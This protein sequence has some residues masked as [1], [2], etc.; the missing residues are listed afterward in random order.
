MATEK[1]LHNGLLTLLGVV[2]DTRYYYTFW[3]SSLEA[4]FTPPEELLFGA[5]FF[6]LVNATRADC[7]L[8]SRKLDT[9]N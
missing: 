1:R 4:V 9:R 8:K 3:W 5:W 7:E 2:L 6:E